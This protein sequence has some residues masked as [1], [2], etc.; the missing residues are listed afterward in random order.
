MLPLKEIHF[1]R[2]DGKKL[3]HIAFDILDTILL[4]C[5]Y[6]GRYI[7][8]YRYG[9]MRMHEFRHRQV[10]T[11]IIHQNQHIGVPFQHVPFAC[12]HI[13]QYRTQMEQHGNKPHIGQFFIMPNQSPALR[14]H[15]VSP[16]KSEIRFGIPGFQFFHQMR[17]M[18]IPTGLTDNQI[19]FHKTSK[20]LSP[21]IAR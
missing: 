15:Q 14:L 4:P 21:S 19:I 13:M 20:S 9:T 18:Q 1:K 7:V 11:G 2:K 17:R 3:V 6:L 10:E 12:L 5:P 8:I 16:Q